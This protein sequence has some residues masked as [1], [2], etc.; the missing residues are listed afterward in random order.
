MAEQRQLLLIAS[1][2]V[3]GGVGELVASGDQSPHTLTTQ[4]VAKSD[5]VPA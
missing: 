5:V 4:L 2:D 3:C 1:D